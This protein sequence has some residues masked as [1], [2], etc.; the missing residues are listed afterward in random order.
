MLCLF[1]FTED[2]C[3]YVMLP[4]AVNTDKFVVNEK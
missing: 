2:E 3:A 1:V 4:H